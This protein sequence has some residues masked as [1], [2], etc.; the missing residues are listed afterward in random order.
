MFGPAVH[1]QWKCKKC[2][3]TTPLQSYFDIVLSR[4]LAFLKETKQL[5]HLKR[6]W[7]RA[8]LATHR[9][10]CVCVVLFVHFCLYAGTRSPLVLAFPARTPRMAQRGFAAKSFARAQALF[11]PRVMRLIRVCHIKATLGWHSLVGRGI[12]CVWVASDS[13]KPKRMKEKYVCYTYQIAVSLS[14]ISV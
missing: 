7:V 4:L 6:Q 3:S 2:L 13:S 8:S 10:C 1:I 12:V 9:C 14:R 11:W 5:N